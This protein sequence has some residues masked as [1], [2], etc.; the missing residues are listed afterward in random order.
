[1]LSYPWM[2]DSFEGHIST[3]DVL[4]KLIRKSS[5]KDIPYLNPLSL[6]LH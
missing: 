5:S 1:M 6:P 4:N 2:L 3:T